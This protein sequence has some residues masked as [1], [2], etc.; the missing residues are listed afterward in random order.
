MF[1]L[2]LANWLGHDKTL[3]EAGV[4]DNTLVVLRLIIVII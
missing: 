2:H 3:R 4:D 1:L